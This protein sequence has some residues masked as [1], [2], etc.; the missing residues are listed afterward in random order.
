[1]VPN[2]RHIYWSCGWR[3]NTDGIQIFKNDIEIRENYHCAYCTTAAV[4]VVNNCDTYFMIMRIFLALRRHGRVIDGDNWLRNPPHP[5]DK[6]TLFLHITYSCLPAVGSCIMLASFF[7]LVYI[8]TYIDI[9]QFVE[10]RSILLQLN[11]LSSPSGVNSSRWRTRWATSPS[12]RPHVVRAKL[13]EA[14]WN[15][16]SK[17]V[18]SV[19]LHSPM[20]LGN[21][22]TTTTHFAAAC[23]SYLV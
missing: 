19:Y 4:V 22:L 9:T 17:Y 5:E 11:W 20:L 23:S 12:S 7:F 1:M 15:L 8:H 13:S 16:K 18:K 14:D 6:P 3:K 10:L 21:F 2:N